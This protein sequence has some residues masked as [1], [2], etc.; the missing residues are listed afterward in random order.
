MDGSIIKKKMMKMMLQNLKHKY[1]YTLAFLLYNVTVL[2]AQD[3]PGFDQDVIDNTA[4]PI[5]NYIL[6][7]LA[8]A[9]IIGTV[10]LKKK[11]V[12]CLK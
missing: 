5:D 7:M 6:P 10:L 12:N 3:T 4:V 2:F 11:D 8:L 9:L 1:V